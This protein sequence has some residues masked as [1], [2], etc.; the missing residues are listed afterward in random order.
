MPF[1]GSQ[2]DNVI[3]LAYWLHQNILYLR[4]IGI[5]IIA[6]PTFLIIKNSTQAIRITISVLLAFYVVVF[7]TFNY[8]FL[9]DKMF[10][11]A[12]NKKFLNAENNKIDESQLVIG[13]ESGNE[14]KAYPIEIIGYHHQVKDTLSGQPIM[15]TYCTVCRTGRVYKPF[16]NGK[17]EDFR[18]VGMDHYN[19]MFEDKTTGSWWRQVSG[20]AIV[21]PLTGTM[22]DEFPSQQ[23]TLASGLIF[24]PKH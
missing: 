24:I 13:I 21:G 10:L 7:Y 3:E 18:L 16:V 23:I 9:A 17:H 5:A 22:L 12:E 11:Q 19:A 14:S 1:P 2:E 8:R 4:L 20:E 6:Y 15:V